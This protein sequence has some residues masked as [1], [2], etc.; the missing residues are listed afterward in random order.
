M[1]A[2]YFA[3]IE[4]VFDG[5]V[6]RLVHSQPERPLRCAVILRLHSTEPPYH[7]GRALE[8]GCG[9]FLITKSCGKKSFFACDTR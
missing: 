7:V 5:S 3:A 2:K 1:R 4:R 6:R 8:A 9:Q